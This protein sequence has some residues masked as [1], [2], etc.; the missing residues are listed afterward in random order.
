MLNHWLHQTTM[1]FSLL[2]SSSCDAIADPPT[3][4]AKG[5]EAVGAEF[6]ATDA[7]SN[8]LTVRL[9]VD[10]VNDVPTIEYDK[11]FR[12][13]LTNNS[14]QPLRICN[15]ETQAGYFQLSF[16]FINPET[17]EK[18]VVR[19]RQIEDSNV[20]G[21]GCQICLN[22]DVRLSRLPQPRSF[23]IEV[24]LNA[25]SGQRPGPGCRIPTHP[26]DIWSRRNLNPRM[27]PQ[28]TDRQPGSGNVRVTQSQSILSLGI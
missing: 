19:K 26:R 24:R 22:R 2:L 8:G 5:V 25:L 17:G 16:Q 9:D 6:Q 3:V 1:T 12:V 13:V 7:E 14:E 10:R 11:P 18:L 21:V 28:Q 27:L 23:T 20:L 15:P 4:T